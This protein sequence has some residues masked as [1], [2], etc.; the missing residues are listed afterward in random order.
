[1]PYTLIKPMTEEYQVY[2]R[3]E[4]RTIGRAEAI[5][6]VRNEA[7][8]AVV[9]A[10]AH[11]DGTPVTLQGAR[12]GL[13]AAAVPNGGLVINLMRM[14]RVT[15]LRRDAEGRF[16]IRLQPGVIL[17]QLNK[18]IADKRFD[19]TGWD[20]SALA[21]YAAFKEAP[22]QFFTPDPTES[23]CSIGGMVA[24]NASG[25]RSYRYG[26]VREHVS[27]LRL[28]LTDGQI[29]TIDRG[30]VF[31]RGR[32]LT[33]TT[34]QGRRLDIRLP[35]YTMPRTK[36]ASG[37]YV[38]D[39]M[40]AIDLII[41]SDGTLGVITQIE[42]ALQPLPGAIWGAACFFER[43]S[44]AIDFVIKVRQEL[45]QVGALEFFDARCLKL[46]RTARAENPAFGGLP[47]IPEQRTCIY[48]E[49]HCA[50]E[51][52]AAR[53]LF[54]LGEMMTA[55]GGDERDTWVC[56]TVFDRDK[57]IFFRHA[58]PECVN[59]II[60]QR[61][62]RDPVITKLGTDMAVPDRHLKEV[63][64][65]YHRDLEALGLEYAIWG[66]VGNNH[67]HV[68]VLPRT[69]EEHGRTKALYLE[70]A[71]T[72][73]QLGGSVSAEHGV[74]KL[75]AGFLRV[76]YGDDAI[77]Q[78]TALKRAFDPKGLLGVGNLFAPEGEGR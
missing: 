21:A 14:D 70:W 58:A 55:C 42:V 54:G 34:D 45:D 69:A 29:L 48:V 51:Q 23:S 9:L 61:K 25:A 60:D 1:M 20:D 26:P 56:R 49:L 50:D 24:C 74:G 65:M 28:M 66:H 75:K 67:V 27:A 8:L 6:F 5:A 12:T 47:A 30:Q 64:A 72:I 77:S 46:L 57:L 17:S 38:K 53:R 37:Y 78:M 41:G 52:E 73:S 76:M 35:D 63:M 40:D 39:D 62:K 15:G 71:K 31:A 13:A 36:N 33:L 32:R 44:Q 4:S 10:K 2:L 59:M 3:D 18:R 68:N 43:E 22:E 16:Y 11:A 7:E 19:T